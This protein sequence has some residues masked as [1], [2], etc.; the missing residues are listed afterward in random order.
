MSDLLS[1][2]ISLLGGALLGSFFFGGLWWTVRKG[3]VS[4]QPVFWFFGSLV[5]RMS[6]TMVG[7]Y[8][9]GGVHWE[10]WL[11]CL[12]GFVIARYAV[13]RFTRVRETRFQSHESEANHAS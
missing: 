9:I 6:V 4:P 2:A 7:F 10:R 1:I 11:L 12:L 5:L 13:M 8:F 3:A